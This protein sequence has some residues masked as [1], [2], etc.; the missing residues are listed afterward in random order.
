MNEGI[1]S[2]RGRAQTRHWRNK[3]QLQGETN[4][5]QTRRKKFLRELPLQGFSRGASS[6]WRA[7]SQEAGG[8]PVQVFGGGLKENTVKMFF[9]LGISRPE[10]TLKPGIKWPSQQLNPHLLMVWLGTSHNLS[11]LDILISK[12]RTIIE[13]T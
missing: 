10:D 13:S 5:T 3:W 7:V 9:I 1:H 8:L 11:G 6:F 4:T 2:T 12:I